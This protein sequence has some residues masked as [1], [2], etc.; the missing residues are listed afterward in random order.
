MTHQMRKGLIHSRMFPMS[1]A[2]ASQVLK[3]NHKE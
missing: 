2:I 1:S 3:Q